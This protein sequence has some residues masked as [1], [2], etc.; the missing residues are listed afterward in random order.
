M[1][2]K[3][4]PTIPFVFSPGAD[5]FSEHLEITELEDRETVHWASLGVTINTPKGAIYPS[6]DAI[7]K[8]NPNL[9]TFHGKKGYSIGTYHEFLTDVDSSKLA[10]FSMGRIE[11]TFGEA[12][13]LMGFL[14]DCIHREKYYG[15][16]EY[17]VTARIVGAVDV[18]EAELAFA[19]A[20]IRYFDKFRETPSVWAMSEEELLDFTDDTTSPPEFH[21]GAA[22]VQDADPLRFY[23][24]GLAQSDSVSACL[25]FYRVLEYYSFLSN[26]KE[27]SVARH[28]ASIS[29]EDFTSR[30]L[31]IISRD[32]KGPLLR[33]VNQI[34]DPAFLRNATTIGLTNNNSSEVL[35]QNLYAFR[36][37]I[38]HGKGSGGFSLHS[39]SIIKDELESATSWRVAL[40]T[41]AKVAIERFG[42]KLL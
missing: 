11:V 25:Y 27:L 4:K 13:P 42:K 31:T 26:R 9:V 3:P 41:L 38:V 36:N 8:A 10:G 1:A 14:F 18:D 35:G 34:T 21:T 12:T 15:R 19:N 22:G 16:W 30:V 39:P 33:L 24:Y 2:R 5:N 20:A 40:R 23:Y 17:I 32:E 7:E 6:F 29:D 28:N 37:S